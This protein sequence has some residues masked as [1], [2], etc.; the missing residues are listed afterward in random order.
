M[1]ALKRHH[2]CGILIVLGLLGG[3]LSWWLTRPTADELF[4]QGVTALMRGDI[5]AG[6]RIVQRLKGHSGA[7]QYEQ[8]LNG[9]LLLHSGRYREALI[10]LS[11]E[12]AT[13]KQR[14]PVLVWAGECFVK[15]RD[16]ARAELMLRAAAQEFPENQQA[17]RLLAVIYFDLGAMHP[18]LEQL[19]KL[20]RFDPQDYR[21][22][23]MA[24]TIYLDFE[25]FDEAVKDLR[26][27]LDRDPPLLT[28]DEIALD[29]SLGLRRLLRFDDALTIA[30]SVRPSARSHAE[31]A[32]SQLGSGNLKG[33]LSSVNDGQRF[34]A[35]DPQLCR[36]EAQVLIEQKLFEPALLALRK[37]AK[38]EPQD[39]ETQYKL[40]SVLK[41]LGRD[42][43]HLAALNRFNELVALRTRLTELNDQANQ[44]PY[45]ADLRLELADVCRQLGRLD[46]EQ[47]W[48]NAAAAC[49]ESALLRSS[50]PAPGRGK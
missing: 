6:E 25:Q 30:Q 21:P 49:R 33:A 13:G 5:L 3:G 35:D 15:L 37:L 46:L 45:D 39:F 17:A 43:E 24:G 22:Y 27:A 19:K 8:T 38:L 2:W 10:V 32:L 48:R 11:P 34:D 41:E 36:A 9:G 44:K 47:D 18:A 7:T 16:L 31:I 23:H 26:A 28:R 29:L 12:L 20:K 4:A 14:E 40:A 50:Q 42:Q 1:L